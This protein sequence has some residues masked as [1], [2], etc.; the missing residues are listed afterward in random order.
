MQKEHG[1]WI[2][3]YFV[4]QVKNKHSYCSLNPTSLFY[5]ETQNLEK[6]STSAVASI[7]PQTGNPH[8]ED[9][10]DIQN[11]EISK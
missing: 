4:I 2:N 3:K 9:W 11:K 5:S 1:C 8:T 7:R 10:A 6:W